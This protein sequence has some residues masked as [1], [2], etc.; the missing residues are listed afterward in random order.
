MLCPKYSLYCQSKPD[1]DLISKDLQSRLD[2]S[3]LNRFIMEL[4]LE[5][6]NTEALESIVK[7]LYHSRFCLN[8][9]FLFFDKVVVVMWGRG[10][11]PHI[12][13][14]GLM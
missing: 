11:D 3:T 6:I 12:P 1:L 13:F 4:P 14:E 2:D 7:M 10:V 9:W 5:K 8:N